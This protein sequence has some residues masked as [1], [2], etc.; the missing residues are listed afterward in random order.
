MLHELPHW[1]S[2]LVREPFGFLELLPCGSDRAV[3]HG[4]VVLV[5]LLQH[6][7][8]AAK[9]VVVQAIGKHRVVQKVVVLADVFGPLRLLEDGFY[10]PEP[11]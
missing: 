2:R 3:S 1:F 5:H 7:E 6:V 10:V 4:D 11:P 9:V 8:H